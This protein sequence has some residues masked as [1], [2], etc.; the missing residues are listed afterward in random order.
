VAFEH[1]DQQ[2]STEVYNQQQADQFFR[3]TLASEA[4][5]QCNASGAFF[6][7]YTKTCRQEIQLA[8]WPCNRSELDGQLKVKAPRATFLGLARLDSLLASESEMHQCGETQSGEILVAV[9]TK[10]F[11]G[12]GASVHAENFSFPMSS[13]PSKN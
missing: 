3:E 1:K 2:K 9:I 4:Q 5:V 7:L 10:N 8:K 13:E 12:N 6:D 11:A